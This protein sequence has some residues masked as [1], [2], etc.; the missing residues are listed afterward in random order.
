MT[1]VSA[2]H[3]QQFPATS[4]NPGKWPKTAVFNGRDNS[5]ARSTR[6]AM[7]DSQYPRFIFPISNGFYCMPLRPSV[8]EQSTKDR[9]DAML[10]RSSTRSIFPLPTLNQRC[11]LSRV[12][13]GLSIAGGPNSN[14][15]H[16]P[17]GSPTCENLAA[18]HS[19]VCT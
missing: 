5:F 13:G 7:H 2:L 6:F 1:P 4:I 19:I 16:F 3:A 17:S 14:S 18:L 11:T 8:A 9:S 12:D 15:I 10:V